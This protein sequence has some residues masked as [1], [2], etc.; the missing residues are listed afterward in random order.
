MYP[1]C[2]RFFKER[3][4]KRASSFPD[5]SSKKENYIKKEKKRFKRKEK[6]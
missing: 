1:E 6:D 3:E 4:Q 2:T 5:E